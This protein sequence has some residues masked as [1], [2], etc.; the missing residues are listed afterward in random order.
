MKEMIQA[1]EVI[2]PKLHSVY[3]AVVGNPNKNFLEE[4]KINSSLVELAKI[5]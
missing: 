5:G 3:D 1:F 2:L 4:D